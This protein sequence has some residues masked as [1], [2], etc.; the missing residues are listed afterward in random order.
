M[1]RIS[2]FFLMIGLIAGNFSLAQKK[3]P[4][5][6]RMLGADSITVKKVVV[7]SAG[8]K[9]HSPQRATL[10]SAILPGWG[11]AYNRAYW[12]I[13]IVYAALGITGAVYNFNRKQY[14]KAKFAYF[15]LLNNDTA[16]F[17]NVAPEFKNAVLNGNTYALQ[18]YRNDVR[19][20]VDY[21]VL[22]FIFFWGLNV[23]DATVDG[24]LKEFDISD[25]LSLKIKPVINSL[26]NTAGVSFVFT[27]GRN[28]NYHKYTQV[29]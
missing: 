8:K 18:Q 7:D 15:T 10:R 14:N 3:D 25:N 13:P 22:F 6:L 29:R 21:S 4:G 20:N 2:F 16:N 23:V 28:N 9:K 24:H 12:K 5:A 17:E 19:K 1:K 11:Q 27:I 26:P